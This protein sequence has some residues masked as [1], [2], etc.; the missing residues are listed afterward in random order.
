MMYLNPR[1]MMACTSTRGTV[2]F[3]VLQKKGVSLL[4]YCTVLYLEVQYSRVAIP[5]HRFFLQV[6][7]KMFQG[8]KHAPSSYQSGNNIDNGEGESRY[9]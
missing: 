9:V 6:S 5:L 3:P 8:V 1:Y 4:T 7:I 2:I